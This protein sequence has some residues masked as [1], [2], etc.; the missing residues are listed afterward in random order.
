V[1]R[2]DLAEELKFKWENK[3]FTESQ[4]WFDKEM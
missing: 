4:P 2:S 1:G 3:V